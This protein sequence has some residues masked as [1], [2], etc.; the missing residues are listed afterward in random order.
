MVRPTEIPLRSEN[1]RRFSFCIASAIFSGKYRIFTQSTR[2]TVN[3]Q[4]FENQILGYNRLG[5]SIQHICHHQTPDLCPH[6]QKTFH[7]Q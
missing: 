6:G 2:K 5:H 7:G 1:S 4:T 3:S